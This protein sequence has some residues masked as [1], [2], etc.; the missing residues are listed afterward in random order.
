MPNL[1]EI[2]MGERDELTAMKAYMLGDRTCSIQCTK[3]LNAKQLKALREKIQEDY[4]MHLNV[5]NMAL[6]IRG[7]SGEGS[8]PILGM[9][10]GKF[11]DGDAVLHNH[12]KLL[13]KY[14]KSEFSA[15]DLNIKN[16]KDDEVFNIVG[17]EGSPE[18]RDYEDASEK[19]IVKQCKVCKLSRAHEE[20]P[21]RWPRR[22]WPGSIRAIWFRV[23][24]G[25]WG[26]IGTIAREH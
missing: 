4:Y 9:P 24:G 18:S 10:I 3:T 14:H 7:T 8:Y 6:V 22:S 5:D 11:Q 26:G 1:G 13:I 25:E 2:L 19:E 23:V 16:R 15:T 12:Y 20:D 21:A 17:F